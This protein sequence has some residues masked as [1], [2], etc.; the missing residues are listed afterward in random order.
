MDI[1]S[2]ESGSRQSHDF[3]LMTGT[4]GSSRTLT[5]LASISANTVDAAAGKY[6]SPTARVDYNTSP[7]LSIIISAVENPR[8]PVGIGLIS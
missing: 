3:S 1:D 8:R 4:V 2:T 5:V 7:Y 6:G